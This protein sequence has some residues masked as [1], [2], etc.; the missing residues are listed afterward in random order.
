MPKYLPRSWTIGMFVNE[1]MLRSVS[2]GV[3]REKNSLDLVAL[4]I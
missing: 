4:Q 1:E 2:K 3:F